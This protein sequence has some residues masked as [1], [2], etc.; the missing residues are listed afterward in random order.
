MLTPNTLKEFF[1]FPGFTANAT[2]SG[3]F[4]DNVARVVTL[5]RRKKPRSVRIADIAATAVMIIVRNVCAIL[6]WLVG[7]SI[8]NLSA[9]VLTVRGVK[10]CT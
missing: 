2:L 4:G 9:G 3:V 5:R 1:S 8:C 6:A 7:A 10:A